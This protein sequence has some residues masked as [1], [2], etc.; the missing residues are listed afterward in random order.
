MI[1]FSGKNDP[2]QVLKTAERLPLPI[3]SLLSH[4]PK[5]RLLTERIKRCERRT[6]NAMM[7]S[8]PVNCKQKMRG[9]GDWETPGGRRVSSLGSEH[10]LADLVHFCERRGFTQFDHLIAPSD[11]V[12]PDVCELRLDHNA[13]AVMLVA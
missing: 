10:R 7:H 5:D 12:R 2:Y 3:S 11:L 6:N 9:S 4:Y 8:L 13:R 1:F